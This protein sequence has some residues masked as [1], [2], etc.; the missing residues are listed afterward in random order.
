[1]HG[2]E[3]Q[4]QADFTGGLYS[5]PQLE[6][7]KWRKRERERERQE[8]CQPSGLKKPANGISLNRLGTITGRKESL[9]ENTYGHNI[10]VRSHLW[11]GYFNTSVA[12]ET[13]EE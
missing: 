5:R 10:R 1:M 7:G 11:R 13:S 2:V 8:N 4:Q 9:R 3:W 6:N 12:T